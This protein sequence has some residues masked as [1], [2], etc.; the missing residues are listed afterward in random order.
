MWVLGMSFNVMTAMVASLAIGIGVPFGIH[1]SHRFTEDLQ[2]T[3]SVDDAVRETVTHTGG[4]LLGSA[5]TTAA[6]F[7][8]L[9]FASLVPMQQFGIITALTI[10]YS[11]IASVLIEPACLKLWADRRRRGGP[12]VA[13][14]QPREDRERAA[15]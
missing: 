13:A 8:V 1:I 11:L 14:E 9:A 2:R 10:T 4:A 6:G 5:A 3:G 15:A 12:E 7:G